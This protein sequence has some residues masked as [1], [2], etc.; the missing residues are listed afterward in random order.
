MKTRLA[1]A[2][3]SRCDVLKDFGFDKFQT[4]LSTWD[5]ERP[6]EFCGQRRA[7]DPCHAIA[8]ERAEAQEYRVQDDSRR[9]GVLRA[10][11]RHQAGGRDRAAV[12]ALDGAGRLQ[13]AAA[14]RLEYVAEDGS[15]KQPVMVH[16]AL[17]RIGRALLRRADRALCGRVSG[18]A[19]AGAGGDDSHQ[20]AARGVCEQS[21][22][23]A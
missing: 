10:E 17:Y 18:V 5:P 2:W 3:I 7:V 22:G 15:R 8:G 20:R 1:T 21:C 4:E 6:Q 16:R 19:V 11:D 9:S 12:A 14:L 23:S 13:P